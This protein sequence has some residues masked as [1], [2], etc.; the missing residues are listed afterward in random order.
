MF[1]SS[2]TP[3]CRVSV[4]R[5]VILRVIIYGWWNE[6]L[7]KEINPTW[8]LLQ[9]SNRN[10][11]GFRE[12][13]SWRDYQI[14]FRKKNFMISWK[15]RMANHT[16]SPHLPFW[17]EFFLGIFWPHNCTLSLLF[18][19]CYVF[20]NISM[21][22]CQRTKLPKDMQPQFKTF[23]IKLQFTRNSESVCISV[24]TNSSFEF[25]CITRL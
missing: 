4:A 24:H 18:H 25:F 16:I 22:R 19:T 5:E 13:S 8:R 6:V 2:R 1:S 15:T 20:N 7:K 10:R 21:L 23:L 3:R 12:I 11:C 17:F 9:S 14:G